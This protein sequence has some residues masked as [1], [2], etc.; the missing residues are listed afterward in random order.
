MSDVNVIDFGDGGGKKLYKSLHKTDRQP[1]AFA[2][3]DT[4]KS[5]TISANALTHTLVVE[6]PTF[7]GAVVTAICSIENSDSKE[8]Y[9]SSSLSEGST[10]V[11]ATEK[12]L[13]GENTVKIT[14]ST[15]P[16]SSGTC[17]VAMY[18]RGG[19]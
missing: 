16:L 19:N 8:I 13:V 2:T 10:N 5:F 12:P 6:I 14:L 4:V 17:Y 1:L 18:L 7:S 15:D 3:G 9:A 11:I